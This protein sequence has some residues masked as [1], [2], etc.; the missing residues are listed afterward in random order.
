[1]F[2]QIKKVDLKS[3]PGAN[4]QSSYKFLVSKQPFCFIINII[5]KIIYLSFLLINIA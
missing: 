4:M 3:K 2:G 1:M 5:T